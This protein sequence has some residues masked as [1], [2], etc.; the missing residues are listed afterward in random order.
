MQLEIAGSFA[1][2]CN[3]RNGTP[4]TTNAIFRAGDIESVHRGIPGVYRELIRLPTIKRLYIYIHIYTVMT[5]ATVG[6]SS[7]SNKEVRW[8]FLRWNTH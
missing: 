1:V 7:G 6:R 2:R 8:C 4:T 5:T 3:A